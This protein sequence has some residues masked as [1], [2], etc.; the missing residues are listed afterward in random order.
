MPY[1]ILIAT[2]KRDTTVEELFA[3]MKEKVDTLL[4]KGWMRF[5][6][7]LYYRNA[8]T[9]SMIPIDTTAYEISLIR[10]ELAKHESGGSTNPETLVYSMG[11]RG[12]MGAKTLYENGIYYDK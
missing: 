11:G 4:A 10:I 1:T 2:M 12:H 3:E 8:I 6:D 9:Q 5:G 7:V